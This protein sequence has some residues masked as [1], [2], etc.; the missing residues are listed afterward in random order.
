[1]GKKLTID[2][3]RNYLNEKHPGCCLVSEKY[4]NN[5]TKI[6][7]ICENGH[8]FSKSFNKIKDGNQWCK[9]CF[10]HKPKHVNISLIIDFIE[11]NHRGSLVISDKYEHYSK[12]IEL[13][14]ENGHNF[15]MVWH[16]I[17]EGNWC[18]IC[19]GKTKLTIEYIRKYLYERHPGCTLISEIYNKNNEKLEIVCE[20][21]H[22][23][24]PVFHNIKQNNTWCPDCKQERTKHTC[25]KKYNCDNP[26]QDHNIGLKAARAQNDIEIRIHWKTGEELVCKAGYEQKT[27]DYLNSNHIEFLWQPETFTLSTGR[28]YRPDLYLVNEDLWVEIKGWER[29]DAMIKWEEFHTKIK[30]NSELWNK[31][32]LK[33]MKIIK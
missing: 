25:Q 3:I 31:K 33:K 30:P 26:S 20:K 15:S 8:E 7:I 13:I 9:D 27:V 14:C 32:K 1:M 16:D 22:T 6:E 11:K 29:P 23:F 4:I 2:C 24:F 5:H 17:R 21:G 18:A 10:V 28:T 12:K 19:A